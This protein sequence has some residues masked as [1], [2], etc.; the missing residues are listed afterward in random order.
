[1]KSTCWDTRATDS[2]IKSDQKDTEA[3]IP[4]HVITGKIYIFYKNPV[5]IPKFV[6]IRCSCRIKHYLTLLVVISVSSLHQCSIMIL[7][8]FPGLKYNHISILNGSHQD[9]DTAIVE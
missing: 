6:K 9:L 3:S 1:M 7:Y 5:I 8:L 2:I 4:E